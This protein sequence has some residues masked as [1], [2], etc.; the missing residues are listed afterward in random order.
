MNKSSQNHHSKLSGRES[1]VALIAALITLLLIAAITAGMIILSTT[2]TNISSNFR[3]EQLAFFSAK[4][5]IEEARDRMRT[6]A[7]NTLRAAGT[8]PTTLP[9]SGTTGVLYILNPANGETVTPAGSNPANYADDEI[10]KETST[11]AC[12]TGTPKYPSNGSGWF[13][14]VT[15]S[16]TYAAAPVLPW[17]W[18]RVTLKQNNGIAPYYTNGNSASA[19]YVCWNGNNEFASATPCVAPNLSVYLLTTLAVTP[20]GSRRMVQTEIAEDSLAFTAPSALTMDGPVPVNGFSGGNSGNYAVDGTDH[21]GCGVATTGPAVPAIAVTDPTSLTNV[22]G[23]IPHNRD[24]NYTGVDGT[25][26]DVSNVSS[27]LPANL[28]TVTSLQNL[29]TTIKNNVTQPVLNG[30]PTSLGGPGPVTSIPNP[31]TQTDPQ[32]IV[33]TGDLS[34]SGAVTGYGIL[35]VTGTFTASGNVGWNGLI[36]VVGQGNFLGNG[37]G[38][39]SY[40]GAVLVAKTLDAN[41]NPLATVGP[42][43]TDFN[44]NGGG[45]NGINY[46]SGCIANATTL[47]TFHVVA[48]RE[49]MN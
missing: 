35:V 21:P 6:A 42:G 17:K 7:A 20:G 9:G 37:G 22:T 23:G 3:D 36:L 44:F 27:T 12:T 24:H 28:Q 49:L 15:A 46:S 25:T 47:S 40:N 16:A 45:G 26:P 48:I 5:G 41:Y 11:V 19:G 30:M 33:V 18:T 8:L 13:H 29:V 38:N 31:G 10:C 34:L 4:A 32:I 39:N 43:N 1:G 14:T 2:E